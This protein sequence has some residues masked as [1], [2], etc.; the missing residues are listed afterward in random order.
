MRPGSSR[1][2]VAVGQG[3]MAQNLNIGSSM[4]NLLWQRD[5]TLGSLEVPSNPCDSVI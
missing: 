5:W 3:A 1:W 4:G 2:C